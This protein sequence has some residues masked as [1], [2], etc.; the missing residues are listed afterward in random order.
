MIKYYID[1]KLTKLVKD[2]IFFSH[3]T[4][5]EHIRLYDEVKNACLQGLED[6]LCKMV[7]D[8]TP[9]IAGNPT[10]SLLMFVLG[11]YYD[12]PNGDIKIKSEGSY[13]D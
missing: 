4:E 2:S 7:N 5:E 3:L 6:K 11:L 9:I 1:N 8:N 10:N 12:K 13:P